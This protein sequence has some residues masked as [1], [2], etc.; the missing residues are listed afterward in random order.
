MSSR[1]V[2]SE[3]DNTTGPK[4]S[5]SSS[6]VRRGVGLGS[7]SNGIPSWIGNSGD[8]VLSISRSSR[9]LFMG[10]DPERSEDM[11]RGVK[12]VRGISPKPYRRLGRLQQPLNK[13]L[14]LGDLGSYDI[15]R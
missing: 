4:G 14:D 2:D 7:S 12:V 8:C 3:G 11:G 13:L 5:N 9:R 1:G 6:T 15:G 10:D